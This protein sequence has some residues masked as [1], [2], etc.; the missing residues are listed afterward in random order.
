MTNKAKKFER[1]LKREANITAK[2]KE[3]TPAMFLGASCW[4]GPDAD[5]IHKETGLPR[6]RCVRLAILDRA[7]FRKRMDYEGLCD[8]GIKFN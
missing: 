1:W 8:S 5:K 4:A 6:F 7:I 2:D 3:Y